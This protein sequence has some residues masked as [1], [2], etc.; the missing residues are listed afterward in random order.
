MDQVLPPLKP[1]AAAA[2][3]QRL[4]QTF[5]IKAD[6]DVDTAYF[7]AVKEFGFQP[8]EELER[9]VK[10][11][12]DLF[13]APGLKHNKTP[14][15]MYNLAQGV[16]L[17]F[18]DKRVQPWFNMDITKVSGTT[19]RIAGDFCYLPSGGIG[20]VRPAILGYTENAFKR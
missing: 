1:Q 7:R 16:R 15:V 12:R 9:Q 11:R 14:G 2:E 4:C 13:L 19:S 5:D 20:D 8:V 17:T 3:P 6:L 10:Q 18:H